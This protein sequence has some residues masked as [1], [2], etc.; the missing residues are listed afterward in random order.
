MAK[1]ANL[2]ARASVT[3]IAI[4]LAVWILLKGGSVL[5]AFIAILSIMANDEFL[6]LQGYP[7]GAQR[8]FMHALQIGLV[9][10]AYTYRFDVAV[11]LL[12]IAFFWSSNNLLLRKKPSFSV[13]HNLSLAALIYPGLTLASV[14]LLRE[15]PLHI[16]LPYQAGFTIIM[17]L[18][19]AIWICDSLAY[20]FGSAY[21]DTK[22]FPSVSPNKSWEGSIAGFL[23]ALALFLAAS[24]LDL[25]PGLDFADNMVLAVI[26]GVFGQVGDLVE[27]KYKRELGI[28]DSGNILPGH[29]G[30]WDRL[31]SIA[32][33]VPMAWVYLYLRYAIF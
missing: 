15:L 14:L 24:H 26:A 13:T 4:P 25:I 19:A 28:K 27:S 23:G 16:D 33:A 22:I 6:K 31:D 20:F 11:I 30:I 7:G 12:L 17:F 32:M 21:G 8:I 9:C 1:F 18:L 2:T 10:A 3:I 5:L 29:G